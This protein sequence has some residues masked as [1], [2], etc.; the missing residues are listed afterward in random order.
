MAIHKFHKAH[1]LH[2]HHKAHKLMAMR[3]LH[4][5]VIVLLL[6]TM[7]IPTPTRIIPLT[8][9]RVGPHTLLPA[10]HRE[11]LVIMQIPN[12]NPSPLL[13]PPR[14]EAQYPSQDL[15]QVQMLMRMHL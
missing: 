14:M 13:D 4:I 2:N 6:L 8:L 15:V 1:K 5:L 12:P 10:N 9:P 11:V 3:V 7:I